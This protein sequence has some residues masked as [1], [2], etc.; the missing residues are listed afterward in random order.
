M[1]KTVECGSCDGRFKVNED[2][3]VKEKSKFYPGEKKGVHLERFASASASAVVSSPEAQDVG[4]QQAHYQADV[5]AAQIGPPR[6]RRTIS[7]IIGVSIMALMIVVFLLAGG[8]EGSMRDMETANRFVL[9][10]FTTL[11]GCILVIYGN[12]NNMLKGILVCLVVGG[13]LMSMPVIFPG[14]PISA[15]EDYVPDFVSEAPKPE[16]KS[17][18]DAEKDYLDEIGYTPVAETLEQYPA[19]GVVA[20]YIRNAQQLVRDKISDYLYEETGKIT[21]GIS[22]NRGDMRDSGLYGLILLKNQKMSIDE[23]ASLC[24]RFG[25]VNKIHRE[26]RV[27]DV[28]VE[29]FKIV[30]LD[31][32]KSLDPTSSAFYAQQLKALKSFDPEVKL[33]AVTRLGISEPKAM[34]DDITKQL[35][36]ML[37]ES[38][39][40]LKLELINTLRV[41]STE[42]DGAGPVVLE[43]AQ[44][45]HKDGVVNSTVMSFLIDRKVDGSELILMDLWNKEPVAWT[46]LLISL[47]DGAQFLLLPEL[48]KMDTVHVVAAADVLAKVGA[49]EGIPAIQGAMAELDEKGKKALAAAIEEIKKRP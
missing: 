9:V 29:S 41:W 16:E 31:P 27:V 8:P 46:D 11:L 20:I 39:N 42:G 17:K 2:V 47:G 5:S 7:A 26:L 30:K 33:K 44:K 40:E 32:E 1:D 25:R 10:G 13:A 18:A 12:T 3:L 21:R 48:A 35:L 36:V 4:F 23:I 34:R 38:S 6:P 45:L 49:K 43:A 14:N 28:T 15:S 37:P 19:K 24:G 22:Y